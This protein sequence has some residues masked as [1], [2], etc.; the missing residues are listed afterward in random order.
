MGRTMMPSGGASGDHHHGDSETGI[1][2]V[3]GTPEFAFREHH[4]KIPRPAPKLCWW[5]PGRP[6]R[7]SWST[8]PVCDRAC[9][10]GAVVQMGA[11]Q[12]GRAIEKLGAESGQR[13]PDGA[14]LTA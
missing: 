12:G 1:Y 7:Q 2:V 10:P 8:C 4:E 11:V 3:S 6:R 9:R 5:P 14:A 13:V